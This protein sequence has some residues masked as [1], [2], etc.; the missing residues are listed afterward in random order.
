M[1]PKPTKHIRVHRGGNV[2]IGP[3]SVITLVIVLCMAVMGVLAVSTANAT[4]AI[5]GRYA[6]S[7]EE[8]YVIERAG[9]EFV[10]CV[11]AVL[12]EAREDDDSAT[13]AARAVNKALDGICEK[14]RAAVDDRV[15]CTADMDGL[16][17][18]AEFVCEDARSLEVAITIQR[19]VTYRIAE[20]KM[21]SPQQD[22]A[23]A[24]SLWTG[25]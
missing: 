7:T 16:T 14:A 2:R 9:Q 25:A 13:V 17:V 10:A 12:V 24:G 3:I 21:V 19:D 5:S 1:P 6:A 11:D 8:M 4:K 18:S 23:T 15:S 22:A 20:W